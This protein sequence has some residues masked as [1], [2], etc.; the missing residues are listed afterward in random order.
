MVTFSHVYKALYLWLYLYRVT[1]FKE[2]Y[3]HRFRPMCLL[4]RKVNKYRMSFKFKNFTK[5]EY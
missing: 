2:S 1:S 4:D 5:S 3:S